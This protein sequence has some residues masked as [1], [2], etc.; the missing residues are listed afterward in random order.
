MDARL[1]DRIHEGSFVPEL[2]PG[3]LDEAGRIAE[4]SADSSLLARLRR[5]MLGLL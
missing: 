3:V 1:V 2:W 4:A 5:A